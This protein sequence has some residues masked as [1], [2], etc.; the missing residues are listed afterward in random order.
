MMIVT[1]RVP[2]TDIEMSYRQITFDVIYWRPTG[3]LTT[4]SLHCYTD[5]TSPVITFHRM[6]QNTTYSATEDPP[7]HTITIIIEANIRASDEEKI[8]EPRQ[9]LETQDSHFMRRRQSHEG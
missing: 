5:H 2:Q 7:D 6:S 3:E 1:T 8:C 9:L 4:T